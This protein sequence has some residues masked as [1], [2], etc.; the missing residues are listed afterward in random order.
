M[1]DPGAILTD[2]VS[3]LGP[4]GFV[5]WLVW[6]TTHHT[7]PRLAKSFEDAIDR[8]RADF[9]EM[10]MHQRQDF[11]RE[12]DRERAVHSA[13]MDRLATAVEKLVDG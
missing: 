11:A 4:M 10:A 6:R 5:M 9:K 13:Q 2:L 1:N 8:Q 7:I 3:A 12:M